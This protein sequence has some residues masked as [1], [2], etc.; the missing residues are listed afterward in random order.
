MALCLVKKNRHQLSCAFSVPEYACGD[1]SWCTP[2]SI[3][4]AVLALEEHRWQISLNLGRV[5]S[6]RTLK[7]T[8]KSGYSTNLPLSINFSLQSLGANAGKR[9]FIIT[10]IFKAALCH[11]NG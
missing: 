2:V 7:A 8:F 6:C 5:K 3:V 1:R 10:V 4:L 11:T 9:D